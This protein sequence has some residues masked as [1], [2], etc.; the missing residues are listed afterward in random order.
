VYFNSPERVLF[1]RGVAYVELGRYAEA[2]DLFGAARAWLPGGYRRDHGRYAANLAIAA[3]HDGQV[4]R[5]VA[6]GRESLAIAVET[7]SPHTV[8]G[9]CA[10]R[11]RTGTTARPCA[12]STRHSRASAAEQRRRLAL[13]RS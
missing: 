7:G 1:Q 8:F 3:A 2:A 13:G 5:A 10:E 4:D 9:G 11:W 6:S 12:S